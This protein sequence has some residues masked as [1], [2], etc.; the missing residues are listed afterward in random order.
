MKGIVY[1]AD[2]LKMPRKQW[3]EMDYNATVGGDPSTVA[4]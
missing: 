1:V 2:A 4:Y 3:M